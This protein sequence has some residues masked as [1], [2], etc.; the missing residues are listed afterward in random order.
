METT[1]T[2]SSP[3]F[4]TG[5]FGHNPFE[6]HGEVYRMNPTVATVEKVLELLT[7]EEKVF[8]KSKL[9][10]FFSLPKDRPVI[11]GIIDKVFDD[12]FLGIVAK[13]EDMGSKKDADE[14]NEMF[15]GMNGVEFHRQYY[16]FMV[17]EMFEGFV[18]TITDGKAENPDQLHHDD[19]FYTFT[20]NFFSEYIV[21]KQEKPHYGNRAEFFKKVLEDMNAFDY[22]FLS[23]ELPK[24][25]TN[26]H[27][28]VWEK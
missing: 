5:V 26:M 20:I 22:V 17:K 16:H 9:P 11:V 15:T 3:F 21:G 18:K 13:E 14:F 8:L 27:F 7:D 10:I 28:L 1:E 25:R 12:P 2:L 4:K 6:R 24:D 23:E 19:F